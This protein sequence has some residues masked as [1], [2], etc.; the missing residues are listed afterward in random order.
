MG[1]HSV[2]KLLFL[3][4]ISQIAWAEP[5]PELVYNLKGTIVKVHTVTNTGRQG[6]GSGVVVAENLVATNCHVLADSTGSNIT[7]MGET[8]SPV[9][10]R[11]DW[12]HDVC[13]LRFE[14]LPLKPAVLGDS[15]HLTYETSTFSVGFPGGAPKPLTTTGKIKALYPMDDSYVIRTS[16]S[17]QM[18]ASGS[19][20]FDDQGKLIGMNTFKSP[21]A[22]GYFYNVPAK[23]IKAAMTL[24]ET[25]KVIQTETPFWDAT[26]EKRPYWMQVVLPMQAGKWQDLLAVASAWQREA[27]D[28]PEAI[29]YLALAQNN[30][31]EVEQAKTKFERVLVLNPHHTS[32]ILALA[33]I[34]K[35]QGAQTALKDFSWMLS[36]LDEGSL[37]LLNPTAK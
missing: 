6:S 33:K 18:G 17:F 4:G 23:W 35:E 15:N 31:G 20:L 8:Y 21:G 19:P 34:A 7:A 16:A 9:G 36:V 3:L 24:P 11:A 27:P 13:I 12:K 10:V 1:F 28:D 22:N 30:L 14:F 5:S 26:L 2:S 29:Y 32:S 37:E 25:D